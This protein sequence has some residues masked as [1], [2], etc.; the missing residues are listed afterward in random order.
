VGEFR[1]EAERLEHMA[2][3]GRVGQL[4]RR[5]V[6]VVRRGG[7]RDVRVERG[8]RGGGRGR[9]ERVRVLHVDRCGGRGRGR[10]RDGGWDWLGVRGVV[11]VG[12][13][14]GVDGWVERGRG[15]Q[16]PALWGL[17]G[18]SRVRERASRGLHL[19]GVWDWICVGRRDGTL[20]RDGRSGRHA[21][22]FHAIFPQET[23]LC[24]LGDEF[25][26]ETR[27]KRGR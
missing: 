12:V 21:V 6:G 2:R 15:L 8:D 25:P 10:L 1:A 17:T 26:Q 22:L 13:S 4:E 14:V 7:G 18:V 9:V 23:A 5:L 24:I 20:R 27:M 11:S 3:I 19:R 16:R